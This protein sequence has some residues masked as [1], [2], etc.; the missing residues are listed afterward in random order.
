LT[1]QART[2]NR[3]PSKVSGFFI[4]ASQHSVQ[5]HRCHISQGDDGAAR[6][7]ARFQGL[8][9]VLNLR[10][11]EGLVTSSNKSSAISWVFSRV[12]MWLN[13]VWRVT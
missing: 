9:G 7:L 11:G 5:K 4:R 13:R 2:K 12:V 1:L 10:Q 3:C 8:V 6:G